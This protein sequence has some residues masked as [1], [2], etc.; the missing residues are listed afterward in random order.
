MLQ[1]F[2]LIPNPPDCDDISGIMGIVL[3][4]RLQPA[5]MDIHGIFVPQVCIVSD[6]GID[7]FLCVYLLWILEQ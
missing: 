6:K 4:L 1:I 3:Y 2:C 7:L 5:D